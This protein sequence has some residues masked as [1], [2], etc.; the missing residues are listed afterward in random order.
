MNR[1]ELRQQLD[2]QRRLITPADARLAGLRASRRA[3]AL[4][5]L[6]RAKRIAAYYPMGGEL[7]CLA[8]ITEAWAR[9]REVYLP[10]LHGARLRFRPYTAVSR[11]VLNRFRI[12]EPVG[13]KELPP[14]ALDVAI[15]PLVAFDLN[16]NRLG[17]GGGF[18]DRSFRF[19]QQRKLWHHPRLVGFAYDMQCVTNIDSYAWDVPLDVAVTESANYVF[20][21]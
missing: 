17:M 9:G 10:V 21:V 1:R 3:W 16:G 20:P 6:Q 4:P 12:P 11:M 2:S 14:T 13:G 5:L 19:L 7:D 18:Y 15:T 8:L